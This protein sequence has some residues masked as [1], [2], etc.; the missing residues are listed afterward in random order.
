[1]GGRR[2]FPGRHRYY[3]LA[4]VE[5]AHALES[6]AN[7][8]PPCTPRSLRS[9]TRAG[10]LRLARTCYDHVAGHLGV[11]LMGALIERQVLVGGDGVTEDGWRTLGEVGVMVPRT[12]RP[13][14][15]YCVDWTEQRHH[16][17]GAVGA[18]LLDGSWNS[19]GSSL[20]GLDVD[21]LRARAAA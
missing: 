6:L 7:L 20:A 1:M 13:A 5:V 10:A 19:G 16:L 21:E 15:R 12:D 14:V 4:S 9:A 3:S 2:E 11:G 8:A 18:A 17:A